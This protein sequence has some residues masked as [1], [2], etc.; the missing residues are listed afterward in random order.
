MV[1]DVQSHENAGLCGVIVLLFL[2]KRVIVIGAKSVFQVFSWKH[3][4]RNAISG[5]MQELCGFR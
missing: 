2:Y 5:V 3:P 1:I 4:F